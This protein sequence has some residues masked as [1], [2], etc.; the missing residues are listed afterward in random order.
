MPQSKRHFLW[1]LVVLTLTFHP[2]SSYANECW[3]RLVAFSGKATFVTVRTVVK[4]SSYPLSI[5]IELFVRN[6]A[7]R[8]QFAKQNLKKA[9]FDL[10]SLIVWGISV[11][12]VYYFDPQFTPEEFYEKTRSFDEK[13][14]V[15]CLD[16]Y[17]NGFDRRQDPS[18]YAAAKAVFD[19]KLRDQFVYLE[20]PNAEIMI[21]QLADLVK[22]RSKKICRLE[23]NSHG[24]S[25]VVGIGGDIPPFDKAAI[26]RIE[27]DDRIFSYDFESKRG[28]FIPIPDLFEARAKIRFNAC[29]VARGD[30][31]KAF[32]S[33]FGNVFMPRGGEIYAANINISGHLFNKHGDKVIDHLT[34]FAIPGG[35]AY[36]QFRKYERSYP[37]DWEEKIRLRKNPVVVFEVNPRAEKKK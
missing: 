27:R 26:D 16:V 28:H 30:D 36:L 8:D 19:E 17:V 33:A 2:Q 1:A 7:S 15:D 3:D 5:P 32:M 6:L 34:N 18:F 14:D 13:S 21:E 12:G 29:S 10:P 4:G 31:G 22:S 9:I 37:A 20:S 23:V 11:G 25:G 35:V 24:S